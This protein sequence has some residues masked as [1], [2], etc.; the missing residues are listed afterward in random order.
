LKAFH[1]KHEVYSKR[2]VQTNGIGTLSR[3]MM[4]LFHQSENF[5]VL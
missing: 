5:I 2:V 1:E 3:K 4:S